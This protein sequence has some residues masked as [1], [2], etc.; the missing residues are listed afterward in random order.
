MRRSKYITTLITAFA[1]LASPGP[2]LIAQAQSAQVQQHVAALKQSLAESQARLKQYEWIETTAVSLK[3]EEKSRK[4]NRCYYG[5]DGAVQKVPVGAAPPQEKKRGL[6]GKIIENKKEELT[7][8]MQ[9]AV[10][11]VKLYVPPTPAKIQASK[12]A[13]KASLEILEPGK[14][15]RLN[16]R[17]YVK[18]GDTL[19]VEV[20]LAGHRVLGLK[21]STYLETEKDP[22]SLVVSFATLPDAAN[23]ASQVTLNAQAKNVTVNVTNSGHRKIGG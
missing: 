1:V 4:Q 8:Y 11:L 9:Q 10:G 14:R 13:G 21:V 20:D 6:R 15:I 22:V 23:Y 5:A 19:S 3:G 12:D 16:F 18:P 7:D 17:D 2:P